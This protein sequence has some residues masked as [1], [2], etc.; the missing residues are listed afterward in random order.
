LPVQ[1]SCCLLTRRFRCRWIGPWILW[2]W[3]T[4]RTEWGN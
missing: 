4:R 2:L 3:S 1:C